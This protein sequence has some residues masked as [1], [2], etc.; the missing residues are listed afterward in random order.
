MKGIEFLKKIGHVEEGM[1]SEAANPI[2]KSKKWNGN[3]IKFVGLAACIA[4]F[5]GAICAGRAGLYPKQGRGPM[6]S[7]NIGEKEDA[8]TEN[9]EI[10][11]ETTTEQS[12]TAAVSERM[13]MLEGKLYV[14]VGESDIEAR[15]GMMD[16]SIA[17]SVESGRYPKQHNQSNFGSGYGYQYVGENSIDVKIDEQ[18]IRF[19]TLDTEIQ[20]EPFVPPMDF[21][22]SGEPGETVRPARLEVSLNTSTIT[23][24][25]AEFLIINLGY[26]NATTGKDFCIEKLDNG[27]WLECDYINDPIWEEI[28]LILESDKETK[29]YADWS[30]I[31]GTL[32]KGTYRF[33]K[34]INIDGYG[35]EVYCEFTL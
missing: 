5:V 15:C 13:V 9:V 8:G 20:E 22:G 18:W 27:N 19:E 21:V 32:E 29:F 3:M 31:Y 10:P 14:D 4:V 25:G 1:I 34:T 33:R 28:A 2:K 7:G 26:T 6:S 23:A 17:S 12:E 35:K 24:D 11:E 30:R 16:G